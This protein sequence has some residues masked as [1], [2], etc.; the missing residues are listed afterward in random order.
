MRVLV[1]AAL[2]DMPS[3]CA[4]K[5]SQFNF[6]AGDQS[7]RLSAGPRLPFASIKVNN[8]ISKRTIM[9]QMGSINNAKLRSSVLKKPVKFKEAG[10]RGRHKAQGTKDKGQGRHKVQGTREESLLF[11]CYLRFV[12]YLVFGICDL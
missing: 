7:I 4:L 6:L 12:I 10:A 8:R 2:T 11:F 9:L 5:S 1:N 3:G